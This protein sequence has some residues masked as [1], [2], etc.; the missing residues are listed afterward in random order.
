MSHKL[1]VADT[2]K[3]IGCM[4]CELACAAAN[5]KISFEAAYTTTLA[6]IARNRVVKVEGK[7]APLQCMHCEDA[8]CAKVCPH[9]VIEAM[10]DFVKLNEK[11]CVGCGTCV[12]ICPYGAIKLVEKEGRTF[13]QKCN[14]CFEHPEGP[15]CI[16]VCTTDAIR[17]MDKETFLSQKH[18]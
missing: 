14:L 17:V 8:S 15:S 12:L 11:A 5:A 3:C 18:A 10:D 4:S 9:G 2:K 13:A 16:R 7:T 1:I 6:L